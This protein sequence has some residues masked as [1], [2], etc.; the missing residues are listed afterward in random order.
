MLDRCVAVLL[1]QSVPPTQIVVVVGSDD[2]APLPAGVRVVPLPHN[3]GYAAAANAGI[4]ALPPGTDVLLLNDDTVPRPGFVEALCRARRAEGIYQPRILLHGG[5]GMLDNE[6]HAWFFDGFN[7][8]RGRGRSAPAGPPGAFSGA[9]VLLTAGLLEAVGGFDE[10]LGSFG[11]DADLSLRAL[12]R[13]FPI[14]AV[15]GA[16]IE[17]VLGAS[18]GRGGARKVYLVERNRLRLALRSL[19][20]TAVATLPLWTTLR[21]GLLGAAA[22][23]GQG[24]GATAGATGALASVAGMAAGLAAAPDALRKRREDAAHWTVGE[25]D[26]WRALWRTRAGRAELRARLPQPS[27]EASGGSSGRSA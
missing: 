22:L 8:A 27:G 7:I 17:H 13:G 11:E 3:P 1:A 14:V 18:W 5:G 4:A 15:P 2:P 24:P 10:D 9:A 20:A 26:T 23:S 25:T 12:R 16:T 19:P 6:G 21:L